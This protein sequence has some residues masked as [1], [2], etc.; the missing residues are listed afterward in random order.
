MNQLKQIITK[1]KFQLYIMAGLMCLLVAGSAYFCLLL[2][3]K[4]S[5]LAIAGF[6]LALLIMAFITKLFQNKSTETIHLIHQK[7]ENT[8]YSLELLAIESPNLAQ[9][10]QLERLFSQNH[11]QTPW[12][13]KKNLIVYFVVFM[14]SWVCYAFVPSLLNKQSQ[15]VDQEKQSAPHTSQQISI[16]VFT[17]AK[18]TVQA[19]AYTGLGIVE[20]QNMNASAIVGSLLKW[21]IQFSN[22]EH[23]SMKL[24]NNQGDE[25]AFNNNKGLFEHSDQLLSSGLYAFKAYWNDSLIYQSDYYRLEAIPD[26]AP[27]IEPASKEL[28][29]L[30]YLKDPKNVQ[31]SAKISDD[32]LVSQAFIVATLARGSGENVKFREVKIPISNVNF[33]QTNVIKNIDLKALNFAPGDELY[34]YWAAFDNKRPTPNYTKS[35]TYF[36]VYKDTTQVEEADLA[37]MAMN[38]MPEYFRS[39]RQIIIDTEKLIAKRKKLPAKEFNSTSN[40]IGF[41]Q[42]ALR[43]RYGQYLGEEFENS[44]GSANALPNENEAGGDLLKGFRHAHD[45]GE[46]DHEAGEK[47]EEHDHGGNKPDTDNKDPLA[48]LL[49]D[50][51]HSHDDGEA[52]TFYEQSTRSLLK[53][54]LEQMWQSELHLRMYE[55]EKAIPFE[56]KALEYLKSAQHKARTF[57]KKT[58]FDPPP[59]KEKEKRL[60]GELTKFNEKFSFEKNY[61]QQQIE[62]LVAEVIGIASTKAENQKLSVQ[63]K[64]KVLLLSTIMSSKII[65][66]SLNNWSI[67]TALQKMINDKDL[68]K[69]ETISLQNKLYQLLN[70][71]LPSKNNLSSP[72]YLGEKKLEKAFWKNVSL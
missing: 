42:K 33:K 9:Q 7:I 70:K 29:K 54:A 24:V 19:P 31:I 64:Q 48:G 16:P 23:L 26:L 50:Y 22:T 43:L 52:N 34:Y 36:I 53:M 39:Q 18:L 44:I 69:A 56:K 13:F 40:E 32:F 72:S 46:H 4:S 61:S 27:K 14:F 67:L 71:T 30:H 37:T 45:E 35:D 8:E 63:N 15:S 2:L 66:S 68:S 21:Q 49:A 60:T 11:Y 51:V 17:K 3:V 59:I 10:L 57:V 38:I 20:S 58:S 62:S 65:N 28:Y 1:V 47:H 12:V 6:I 41:D 25:I 5:A 55:P